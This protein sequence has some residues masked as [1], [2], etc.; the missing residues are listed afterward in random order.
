LR[1][2]AFEAPLIFPHDTQPDDRLLLAACV[3][4]LR[5]AGTGRNRGRGRLQAALHADE[6]GRPGADL[7]ADLFQQF[8]REVRG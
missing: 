2:T 1:D 6:G 3:M 7:T 4:A 8:S 5:R